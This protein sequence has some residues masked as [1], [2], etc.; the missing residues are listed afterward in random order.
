MIREEISI[1]KNIV[2]TNHRIKNIKNSKHITK[3]QAIEIKIHMQI[4][5][6]MR[7]NLRIQNNMII[8]I[9]NIL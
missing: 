7:K 6:I 2:I 3:N 5:M 4:T 8:M 1:S 9:Y